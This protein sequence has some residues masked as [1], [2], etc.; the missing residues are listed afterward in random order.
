V[1]ARRIAERHGGSLVLESRP[2]TA[3][4]RFSLY[5]PPRPPGAHGAVATTMPS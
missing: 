5:L 3:G 2:G 4:A 1:A